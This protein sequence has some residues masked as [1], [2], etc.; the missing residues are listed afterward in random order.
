[1]CIRDRNYIKLSLIKNN[2]SEGSK[3]LRHDDIVPANSF[4]KHRERF[5]QHDKQHEHSRVLPQ[6]WY[7]A[8]QRLEPNEP[9]NTEADTEQSN[10]LFSQSELGE[11]EKEVS[12]TRSD[13]REEFVKRVQTFQQQRPLTSIISSK[14]LSGSD[15][16]KRIVHELIEFAILTKG[17]YEEIVVEEERTAIFIKLPVV[18]QVKRK[19]LLSSLLVLSGT[20]FR[21]ELMESRYLP[22]KQRNCE[23]ISLARRGFSI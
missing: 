21:L 3:E 8:R 18:N 9:Q 17:N 11:E 22:A 6:I 5:C 16:I 2:E 13:T 19:S 4:A 20:T 15:W 1:M 10:D 12:K 7:C 23:F 14:V